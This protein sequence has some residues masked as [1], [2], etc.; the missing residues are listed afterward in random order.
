MALSGYLYLHSVLDTCGD[1]DLDS[2]SLPLKAGTV[3]TAAWIG[4][5]AA[6]AAAAGAD[7]SCHCPSKEGVDKL[8][9][10]AGAVT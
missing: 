5:N 9:G 8:L 4:N 7:A 3:A 6:F 10:A 2:L 1:G